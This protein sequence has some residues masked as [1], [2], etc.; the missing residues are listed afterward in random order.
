VLVRLTATAPEPPARSIRS[1]KTNPGSHPP[2][3]MPGAPTS[4]V[5]I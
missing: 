2:T 1:S 4:K 5:L 3:M